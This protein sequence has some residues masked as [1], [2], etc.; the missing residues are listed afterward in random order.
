MLPSSFW[1]RM[2]TIVDEAGDKQFTG[3]REARQLVMG[4]GINTFLEFP[5]TG[6]GAGQFKNYNPPER[7]A[8]WLETH[9]VLIQ[10]A[11]ETGIFGLLA[12]VFLIIRAVIAAMATRRITRDKDWISA[13][14]K[15]HKDD[16]AQAL[17]EHTLGLIAGLAGWFV[18]ALF[19]S[20]AYNWTFYY[21]LALLVAGRE[22]AFDQIRVAVPAKLKKISVR[23][24]ALSTQTAS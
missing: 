13:M 21:V 20:V 1:D 19:A 8:R 14:H 15:V 9:N 17:S 22:L 3:S 2:N 11:A 23:T 5:V 16:V 10:V 4:D 6:V 12:F 18:C 24:P 7:R